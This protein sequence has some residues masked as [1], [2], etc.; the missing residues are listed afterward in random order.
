MKLAIIGFG[1]VGQGLAEILHE[2]ADHLRAG[3]GL[4]ARLVAVCDV[5]RGALYDADGLDIGAVLGALQ[6]GGSLAGYPDAPGLVRGWDSLTTIR[7]S[8]ADV[9]VEATWTNLETGEPALTHMRTA[10]EAGKHVVTS[11]KGPVA[12]AYRELKAMADAHGVSWGIEGTVMSGSPA[13]RLGRTALAG[14]GITELRGILNGTTNFILTQMEAGATYAGALAEA[15]RLGYAEADPTADVEGHD[16]LGKLLILAAVVVGSPLTARDVDRRGI[17][18]L[19]PGDI[20]HAKS[21]GKRWKLI[22]QLRRV[23]DRLEASVAPEMID[24]A[25]PLA[26]VSGATNAIT[27]VTD[28]LGEVTL[29]GAGAG[30]RETGF[31]LLSDLLEIQRLCA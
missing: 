23:G 12:L 14:A 10:F 4:E 29:V 22:A 15:Q 7:E 17:T 1:N 26:G 19:T 3:H 30:R 8:N 25:H 28:F 27:Y 6:R 24:A 2:K 18:G 20:Q 9:V 21:V 16:A 11:N 5:A 13:L 31:A